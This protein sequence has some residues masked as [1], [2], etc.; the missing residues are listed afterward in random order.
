MI[1]DG[2]RSKDIY[3]LKFGFWKFSYSFFTFALDRHGNKQKNAQA[4]NEAACCCDI[5][6][7][8]FDAI[9]NNGGGYINNKI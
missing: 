6:T 1:L 8:R 3:V 7:E 5:V 4:N 2:K 9:R